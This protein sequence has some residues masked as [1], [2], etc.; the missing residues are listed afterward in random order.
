MWSIYIRWGTKYHDV[1]Q[2]MDFFSVLVV[3]SEKK[4][5]KPSTQ[6]IK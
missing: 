3:V 6:V 4:Q 5:P 2:K 1:V